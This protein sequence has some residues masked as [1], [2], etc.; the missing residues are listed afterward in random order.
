MGWC[1]IRDVKLGG[2]WMKK[3]LR[4]EDTGARVKGGGDSWV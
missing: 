2:G 1:S 3:N 4:C